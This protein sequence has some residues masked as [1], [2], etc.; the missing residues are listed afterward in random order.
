MISPFRQVASSFTRRLGF[1]NSSW[2]FFAY[3]KLLGELRFFFFNVLQKLFSHLRAHAFAHSV[4]VARSSAE[5]ASSIVDGRRGGGPSSVA[6]R[7]RNPP[8]E[9]RRDSPI[10]SSLFSHGP[11][12]CRHQSQYSP[13]PA[14]AV[15][16]HIRRH[17][18]R[19]FTA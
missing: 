12:L 19:R 10:S 15:K 13:D 2:A 14:D 1:L 7:S 4:T 17:T 5:Q 3:E 11:P 6:P 8:T 16:R 9:R 18:M